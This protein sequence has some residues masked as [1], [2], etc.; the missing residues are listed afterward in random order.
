[1]Q[2]LRKVGGRRRLGTI[3]PKAMFGKTLGEGGPQMSTCHGGRYQYRRKT[4]RQHDQDIVRETGTKRLGKGYQ[5][6]TT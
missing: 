2:R 6:V 1:M 5:V 3:R 4:D